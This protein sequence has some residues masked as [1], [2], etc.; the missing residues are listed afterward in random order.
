[1]PYVDAET[2]VSLDPHID[3]LEPLLTN[4]GALNYAI[5]RLALAA[6]RTWNGRRGPSYE[7]YNAAVGVLSCVDRELY[8]QVIA[9]YEDA[10]KARNGEVR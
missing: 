2:R 6:V 5:T 7:A 8:R 4:P 10:A 3:A 9:P 1:M